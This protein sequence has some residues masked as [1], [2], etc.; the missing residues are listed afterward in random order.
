MRISVDGAPALL[1]GVLEDLRVTGL[2]PTS[3]EVTRPTL[4][5]VFLELTGNRI[6]NDRTS[7]DQTDD[8]ESS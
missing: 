4:D 7:D 6:A 1:P 3:I 2:T 8:R 5:D